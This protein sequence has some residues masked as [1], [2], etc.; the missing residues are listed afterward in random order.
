MF[1]KVKDKINKAFTWVKTN[2]KKTIVGVLVTLG[3]I[4][5]MGFGAT[6]VNTPTQNTSNLRNRWTLDGQV[7]SWTTGR[8]NDSVSANYGQVVSLA[9]TTA[10]VTGKLGQA[11]NFNGTSSYISLGT[12][13]SLRILATDQMTYSA[14]VKTT[15]EH[16]G[17]IFEM[18]YSSGNSSI[19]FNLDAG[20]GT[21]DVSLRYRNG[22]NN[23]RRSAEDVAFEDG[24]WHH[25]LAT[26][27]GTGNA[28]GINIYYDGVLWTVYNTENSF[29][30]PDWSAETVEYARISTP[31]SN[32]GGGLINGTV[33]DV[34]IY[35]G[36]LT[37]AQVSS[38]YNE[39]WKILADDNT[40]LVGYWSF[41]D[42]TGTKATDFSGNGNT[43]TLTN[44]ENTDWVAGRVG[45]ALEIGPT[46]EY[47][48]LSAHYADYAGLSTGAISVWFKQDGESAGYPISISDSTDGTFT[49]L[50]YLMYIGNFTGSI[51]NETITFYMNNGGTALH[52]SLNK[53]TGFYSD[54]KWH[55][56][57]VVVNG[58]ANTIY[59]DGVNESANITFPDGSASSSLFTNIT[60]L[61]WMGIGAIK[62]N[63]TVYAGEGITE[64]DEVRFYNTPLTQTQVTTIYN[65]SKYTQ[66]NAP[67]NTVLTSG[68]VGMWSLN[69]Q[70][71]DWGTNTTQDSS[72]NGNTGTMTTMSTTTSPTIGKVGQAFSFDG[73]DN[74]VLV[75]DSD[76]L[77]LATTNR[78]T[79]SAWVKP[80]TLTGEIQVLGKGTTDVG[81]GCGEYSFW[82]RN[83]YLVLFSD[84]YCNWAAQSTA[85][86]VQ[87]GVWSLITATYDGTNSNY[88]INGVYVDSKASDAITSAGTGTF[89]IARKTS[90]WGQEYSG[91][92]DEVRL[93]N[94]V[95]SA[96]EILALYNMGK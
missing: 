63:G 24:Q 46:D 79:I 2:V 8:T 85:T 43:G 84:D 36:V 95:L 5:G 60:G 73:V 61:D 78:M 64:V 87:A 25:V 45:T 32:G 48:D 52:M 13:S 76:S 96:S 86:A 3:I 55:H 41:E 80:T 62:L 53:G 57:V 70:D 54:N 6:T 19:T 66:V 89:R 74:H 10:P 67:Q 9:T 34:R 90:S 42:A 65:S 22:S 4:G 38:I 50:G 26:Y 75:A 40:N 44:M 56:A 31:T 91:L 81:P 51:A 82:L 37:Q 92:Q 88:Y 93:Y 21:G 49:H 69:G 47:V 35:T 83:S 58:S 94:R 77:D 23:A 68:L 17:S 18:K 16:D 11:F 39:G 15:S 27:D 12:D 33:D 59:I 28:S 72:G 1:H 7:T 20:S 14:W 30:P 29:T 71:T